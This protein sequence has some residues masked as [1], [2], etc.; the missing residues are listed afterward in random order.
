MKSFDTDVHAR[1]AHRCQL[2]F[3]S[4]DRKP[5]TLTRPP[6]P[7]R[8]VATRYAGVLAAFAVI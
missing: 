3:D 6:D 1:P 7:F 8:F 2:H 5:P 4:S